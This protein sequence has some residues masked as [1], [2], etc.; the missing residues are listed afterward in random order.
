MNRALTLISRFILCVAL[1]VSLTAQVT[2][3]GEAVLDVDVALVLAVDTSESVNEEEYQLQRTG[4]ASAFAEREIIDA[5]TGGA[6]GRILVAVVDFSSSA[7][8]RI[9]FTLLD[10]EKSVIAFA[11]AIAALPRQD[12]TM[13]SQTSISAGISLATLLIERCLCRPTRKVIDVS[14]DGANNQ[15]AIDVNMNMV[16]T[17]ATALDITINGLAILDG[18]A[19]LEE[20]YRRWVLLGHGA[21]LI[22]AESSLS[23]GK[24]MRRKLV[25]E[26]S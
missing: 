5:I 25:R 20:F 21:F 7:E 19:F 9:P 4:L 1:S 11:A 10:S 26:I 22:P 14:G 23:F 3:Q 12:G 13:R 8:V 15:D 17:K 2:A 24:A 16:R 6:L 18:E